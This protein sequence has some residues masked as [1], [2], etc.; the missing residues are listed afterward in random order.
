MI[1]TSVE[2]SATS[3]CKGTVFVHGTCKKPQLL[4][5][6]LGP[7][8]TRNLKTKQQNLLSVSLSS[9]EGEEEAQS[10]G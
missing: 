8:E 3:K 9:S 4:N 10:P 1:N 2:P 5:Q 7:Q 6:K